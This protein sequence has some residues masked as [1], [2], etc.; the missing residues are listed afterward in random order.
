MKRANR[1]C[2]IA[3]L[4]AASIFPLVAD[5]LIMLME[6]YRNHTR[7]TPFFWAESAFVV[8]SG[9][10]VACCCRASAYRWYGC[11]I[12]LLVYTAYFTS[13]LLNEPYRLIHSGYTLMLL[14]FACGCLLM[15]LLC[16][17]KRKMKTGVWFHTRR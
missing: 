4:V 8:L 7:F 11:L 16:A 17:L 1:F 15:E 6:H 10:A 13:G 14:L 12:L 9:F 5:S 3:A 2:F